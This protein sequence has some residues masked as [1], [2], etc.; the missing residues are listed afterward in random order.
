MAT[1]RELK[2][3]IGSVKSN[4]KITG[5]MKMI[6]SAKM[7][8][9]EAALRKLVPYRNQIQLILG[10]L[11]S[12][13]ANFS[14]PLIEAREQIKSVSV[15]V[16]G[17][18]DGLCGAYNL[19]MCKRL[20]ALIDEYKQEYGNDV[21]INVL[22]IGKK[23]KKL[24]SKLSIEGVSANLD[25]ALD[26]RSGFDAIRDFT[27][28]VKSL[29]MNRATDKID[30]LYYHFKSV[31]KQIIT[32]EQL[33]PLTVDTLVGDDV[34]VEKNKSYLF[35]PD[36]NA[37]FNTVL[38]LFVLSA[39]QEIAGENVASEQAARV[40]AMQ[41][42]NDNAKKLLEELQIVYN[43]LRQQGITNELLDILG[44]QKRE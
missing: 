43:K 38:P 40:M 24:V 21:K 30:V 28:Y 41:S 23:V 18:D 20:V 5:A 39:V 32:H 17:S 27:E 11:L 42:A 22:P 31:S 33:L 9:A 44:G 16:F 10:H 4:E 26:T 29:Y 36:A 37:I 34:A 7:H 2:G 35:E 19:T 6:S 1:L 3:R 13:D 15:V 25:I 12:A 8:K 14:S